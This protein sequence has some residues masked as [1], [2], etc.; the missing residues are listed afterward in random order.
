MSDEG[1]I[2]PG[3]TEKLRTELH[4]IASAARIAAA[5]SIGVGI[6]IPIMLTMTVSPYLRPEWMQGSQILVLFWV[7]LLLVSVTLSWTAITLLR[8][9]TN[10]LP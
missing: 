4:R 9:R 7:A 5:C 2:T 6:A 8:R 1:P 10:S 3:E